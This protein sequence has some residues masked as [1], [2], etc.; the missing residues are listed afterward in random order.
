MFRGK[1]FKKT[2]CRTLEIK[3]SQRTSCVCPQGKCKTNCILETM[4][5]WLLV[6]YRLEQRFVR[7]LPDNSEGAVA[8]GAVG[9][10]LLLGM[11]GGGGR[12]LGVVIGRLRG[13]VH[14]PLLAGRRRCSLHEAHG[15]GHGHSRVPTG[16]H[17]SHATGATS[18]STASSTVDPGQT[19]PFWILPQYTLTK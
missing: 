6:D 13:G 17:N 18:T 19:N 16:A 11:S 3:W 1:L 9:L 8:D 4:I 5:I 14:G 12:V 10:D 15:D 7:N 2:L